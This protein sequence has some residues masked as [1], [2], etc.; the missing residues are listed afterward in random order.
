LTKTI[1][2]SSASDQNVTWT[3]S[4]P[5]VATV[6]SSGLVTAK[7]IGSATI[8]VRTVDGGKTAATSVSVNSPAT[9]VDFDNAS[10]GTSSN[11]FDYVGS[12]WV[13]GV[14][15]SDPYLNQTVSFS[16]ASNNF[17][18]L[19]FTGSR[20]EFYSA[21]ASHHG[22]VAISIDNG[23][24]TNVD[25]YAASRQN[26]V[27]AYNSGVLSDGNHILKIR[28]M[29]SRNAA[30]TGAYA[31][32]DYV[33]VFQSGGGG[34]GGAYQETAASDSESFQYYP[35]PVRS[36]DVLH[37]NVPEGTGQIS[38]LDL[39]GV[40][41]RSIVVTDNALEISTD[42]LSNGVYL[43]EYQTRNGREVVKIVVH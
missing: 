24:E 36:G 6:G 25:L 16:N 5:A 21:K 8:T 15:S 11:Q 13:H 17:V 28:V 2:P 32:I 29:G 1:S 42:G 14:S 34:G 10:R 33:K 22:V 18:T 23:P 35:N 20:I 38:L 27:M 39:S 40:Q 12:G 37:V 26:F 19:S 3:S 30:S 43:L 7:A 41:V 4:N 31:I 9:A